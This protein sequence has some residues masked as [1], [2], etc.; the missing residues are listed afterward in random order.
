MGGKKKRSPRLPSGAPV[1]LREFVACTRME[2]DLDPSRLG[3]LPRPPGIPDA[4]A[5]SVTITA[6]GANAVNV[7]VGWGFISLTLPVSVR[8]GELIVDTTHLPD[9]ADIK[10]SV[11]NW[12]SSA[13]EFIRENGKS[14]SGLEVRDGKLKLT[15]QATAGHSSRPAT[16]PSTGVKVAVGLALVAAV[17]ATV[18]VATRDSGGGT[19]SSTVVTS[20]PPATDAGTP[21]SEVAALGEQPAAWLTCDPTVLPCSTGTPPLLVWDG[22]V[23]IT[24]DGSVADPVTGRTGP[25]M[26]SLP[27]LLLGPPP[28]PGVLLR[29]ETM[30]GTDLITGEAPL[31]DRGQITV[32]HPFFGYGP[33]SPQSLH[34]VT[35]DYEQPLPISRWGDY[36]V[37]PDAVSPPW[38]TGDRLTAPGDDGLGA[39]LTVLGILGDRPVPA[40]CTWF[41]AP[42]AGSVAPGG[43]CD[44]TRAVFR[45][46]LDNAWLLGHGGTRVNLAADGVDTLFTNTVF[47]CGVGEV[48]YTVCPKRVDP[49]AAG[50]FVAVSVALSMPL[51]LGGYESRS[52]DVSFEG[53]PTYRIA[54][55]GTEW[56]LTTGGGDTAARAI[57]RGNSLT[58]LVPSGELPSGTTRY[59]LVAY[60]GDGTPLPQPETDIEGV[61]SPAGGTTETPEEFFARLSES[62]ATGDLTFALERLH[63][64]VL[65]AYSADECSA[66]MAERV[67]PTYEITVDTVGATGPWTYEP[68]G[69]GSFP[70]AEATTVTI[71]LSNTTDP[72]EGHLVRID[73]VWR[74]FTVCAHT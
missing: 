15:K 29:I 63:P 9:I 13:N 56:Q 32:Q 40:G 10:S 26:G 19:T 68:P 24:H 6:N 66:T 21:G 62:I 27:F 44:G 61:L 70:Q 16:A 20:P 38:P 48:A 31:S 30:C 3:W 8:G 51:P 33:C 12:V 43:A 37:G 34:L 11:D 54:P 39:A 65:T 64:D 74:W 45:A 22:Q 55:D 42:D 73:G 35:P 53:G 17:G 7:S 36:T 14:L 67:D 60:S 2:I 71:H 5:P 59:Q 1:E 28:G 46:T 4:V 52:F 23:G 25:S 47:P 58:V 69:R 72:Q 50:D 57:I 41:L 18:A 49:P